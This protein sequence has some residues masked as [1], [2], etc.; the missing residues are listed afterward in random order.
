[1][2]R[3]W[4][5]RRNRSGTGLRAK[6]PLSSNFKHE[7]SF[8]FIFRFFSHFLLL[9]EKKKNHRPPTFCFSYFFSN[10]FFS[11]LFLPILIYLPHHSRYIE[12]FRSS[13][14]EASRAMSGG[15]GGGRGGRGGMMRGGG[16][17]GPYDRMGGGPSSLGRG[18]G[19]YGPNRG[20]GGGGRPMKSMILCLLVSGAREKSLSQLPTKKM[21]LAHRFRRK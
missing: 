14:L 5:Q 17:P 11:H 4:D 6:T 7:P 2:W 18:Y 16:R 20:G 8:R 15:G 9:A 21:Y 1:M 19:P 10:H 12:V 13:M 3:G